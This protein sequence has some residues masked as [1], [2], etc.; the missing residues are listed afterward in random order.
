MKGSGECNVDLHTG[1]VG[2]KP[3][4]IARSKIRVLKAD[5][6]VNGA[7]TVRVSKKEC[8][9]GHGHVTVSTY[10]TSRYSD[11]P[12]E[13]FGTFGRRRDIIVSETND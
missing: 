8:K 2:V 10:C 7:L 11:R 13:S 5:Y 9:A 4:R 1:V 12:E 3:S 6:L